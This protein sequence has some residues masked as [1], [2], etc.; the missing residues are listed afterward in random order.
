MKI[1][2]VYNRQSE[3]VINLFGVPNKERIGLK[4]IKLISDGLKEGGHLVKDLEGDKDL[5]D[6]LEEYMPRV[7]KGERPGLV[8]NLSYGIQGQARYTHIPSIL[9]MIGIPYV[10]SGPLAHS[11][12]LD[13]V[14]AKMIFQ[15]HE[16]PTPRFA[17][18]QTPDSPLPEVD[19]PVIVKPKNEAV[20]F[21]IRIAH[22]YE[23]LLEGARNIFDKYDQPVLIE[24]Y[25]EGREINI[26]LIGNNPPD[27]LP[28]VELIFGDTGPRIY[29]MEDKL[30]KSGREITWECP[31]KLDDTTT[32]RAKDI[33]VRAFVTLGCYD[34]ARVDMRLDENGNLYVLEINSLPSIGQHGSYTI[35]AAN[36][37][38]DY[39][40]LV[41]RLV[42]VASVRYF[43]TPKPPEIKKTTLDVGKKLFSYLIE[44]RDEIEK[45]IQEW[46]TF[47][48]RT[49][50]PTGIYE[51]RKKLAKFFEET[52]MIPV[53]QFTDDRSVWT[54]ETKAGMENGILLIGHIDVP[55]EL[56][57]PFIPYRRDPEWLYG[58]GIGSSRAPLV[59]LQF[60]LKALRNLRRLRNIRLGVLLYADEGR[61]CRYSKK[62]IIEA[63]S[64]AKY[65]LVL[66]PGN[67]DNRFISQ[68]RGRR[69]Y[70]VIASGQPRRFGKIYKRRGVLR[71]F[72][73]CLDE[74]A[75]LSSPEDRIAVACSEYKTESYPGLLPHRIQSTV[76]MSYLDAIKADLIEKE[77]QKI[78]KNRDYQWSF[79]LIS[80]RPPLL[81]SNKTNKLIKSL[82]GIASE[83]EIPVEFEAS[84]YPS[85][86]GLVPLNIPALCGV[87]PIAR[88][89]DTPQEAVL[90]IGLMQRTLLLAQFSARLAPQSKR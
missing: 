25:I 53:N 3:N 63:T 71:W 65:V 4:T 66:R 32:N 76:L 64:S 8:F 55:I 48:S 89:L 87:G 59:S 51:A 73:T 36:A 81:K 69:K 30:R 78:L 52:G 67:L 16:I 85:A 72:N 5:I 58:E 15:Q 20:S 1:A 56:S 42:D 77:I 38:L 86:A 88:N 40:Q 44:R 54:W 10:G 35:A 6:K 11:L 26:G 13:K 61:D 27:T 14:V 68:R 57:S 70:R 49:G 19:F 23:E 24:Q 12:A 75:K 62:F 29:T 50:D 39:S 74:M 60:A 83:W 79:D 90:R 84:L 45:R 33:A 47:S 21:G 22:D 9:E 7:L 18:M 82:K 31:A 28:P 34:C 46:T 41:C 2:I 43:G 17:V 80:D 37:G